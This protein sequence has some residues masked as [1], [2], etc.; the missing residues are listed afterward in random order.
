MTTSEL[1]QEALQA[2]NPRRTEIGRPLP[3]SAST[4][5]LLLAAGLVLPTA[6]QSAETGEEEAEEFVLEEV[7][8]TGS[9]IRRTELSDAPAPMAIVDSEEIADRQFVNLID[10]ISEIQVG[11][12][13][14]NKGANDL[15]GDNF[16]FVDLLSL[17]SQRTLTL[18][19]GRRVVPSNMGTVFVPGN[20][21]GAQV[22]LSIINPMAVERVEVVSG[23]GGAVYG[24]DAVAGVVNIIT[25]QDF[26]GFNVDASGSLT[27]NSGK[28][29][30]RLSAIWGTN[31]MDRRLNFMVAGEYSTSQ[32]IRTSSDRPQAYMGSAITNPANG[33]TRNPDYSAAAAAAALAAGGTPPP[34]FLPSTTDAVPS[35]LY[36][37]LDLRSPLY[38][39]NGILMTGQLLQGAASSTAFIPPTTS[40]VPAG[41]GAAVDPQGFAFFAPGALTAAQQADPAAIITALGG[42]VDATALSLAQQRT[43]A[44]Q[45]LQA[46]RPTPREYA[47]QNSLD[48]LLFTAAFG[49]N[50]TYPR[51]ANTD[52]A[53]SALFPLVSAPLQFDPAGNL[54]P[55]N[56]GN[57]APPNPG[58]V[59]SVFGG[60]GFDSYA[61]GY[62]QVRSGTRR[63][64]FSAQHTFHVSDRIRWTGEYLYTDM[65]FKS[66]QYSGSWINSPTGTA[67]AGNRSIPVYLDQN[68]FLTDQA[69]GTIDALAAQGLVIPTLDG[70]RVMYLGRAMT[71]FLESGP[72]ERN[73]VETW[74]IAQGLNGDFSAWGRPFYWDVSAAYGEAKAR[75]IAPDILDIEFALATDVVDGPDGPVCRQ[76]MLAA[77]EPINLRN[78]Q[79]A[80][81]NTRLPLTPTAEQVA[82]CRPLNLFGQGAASQEAIDYVT[83]DGGTTNKNKQEYYAASLGS[84]LFELPGGPLGVV[85]QA[86]RRVESI[87]FSP[88]AAA[89]VGA[90]RNT[91]IL[92]NTG[93]LKFTE[94]GAEVRVPLFGR[95]FAFP[96]IQAL[97]LEG[98]IRRVDREQTT[99]S[100][101]YPDPGPSVEDDVY[102]VGV[103]WI[104]IDDLVLRGNISTSVRSAS[105]VELFS[106][107]SSGFGAAD[108]PC[109]ISQITLGPSPDVRRA[110]CLT[111]VQ[112]LGVAGNEADA[113][114]FLNS[115]V[116]TTSS[117]PAAATGNPFLQN[118]KAEAWSVGLTWKPAFVPGLQV[119]MDYVELEL[120][121]EI[122]LYAPD[123]YLQNC[124]DSPSFPD[125][126]VGGTP[127][128]D[129]ATLGVQQGGGYVIPDINPV[130]GAPVAGGAVPGQSAT[131]Q[132]PFEWAF[133]Q[134]PNFNLGKRETRVLNID[135]RYQFPLDR[136]LGDRAAEWGTL[137]LRASAFFTRQLDLYADGETHTDKVAGSRN[138][139]RWRTR[140]EVSHR[141]GGLGNTLQWFWRQKTVD[142]PFQDPTQYGELTP[143]FVN[144]DYSFLNYSGSWELRDDV[145][146]RF[147]INNLTDARG[148]NG[149]LGDAYDLGVGREFILGVSLRL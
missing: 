43:L 92:A 57:I 52:P 74:R 42:G 50:G 141:I 26:E 84:D 88:G 103:R 145:T 118:E 101:F 100:E 76:Q 85:V 130:T 98:A 138:V 112:M 146:L 34:V 114:A 132:G 102:S 15:Y 70:Q 46:N 66:P 73:E 65:T 139:P 108:H 4:L 77:P 125:T 14:T 113:A 62:Q 136:M 78:P 10:A 117:R 27:E 96:G 41:F 49:G 147:T 54:V 99:R 93:E 63:A 17:G 72:I 106:A 2:R 64:T 67:T 48:P 135:T 140:A 111:A 116:N 60:E 39:E 121:Q 137:A 37:P 69:L 123:D 148:P 143:A 53:T 1:Y 129:L 80:S 3:T 11:E 7:I 18:I 32:L 71:D 35:S 68:P 105:L 120:E 24:A 133:Y 104:P 126:Q 47:L 22:D 40:G 28:G 142:D 83:A 119:G 55:Y 45:L 127:V 144:S 81:I 87:G 124:F 61:L 79:L 90:A 56:I 109:S 31:L 23:T 44:L 107:P 89:S 149:P 5:S 115:L 122:A 110:N 86:E 6:A 94:Y 131:V 51:I 59:G 13:L 29:G 75:N 134:Y 95:D 19:N 97:E 12:V 33:A 38:N 16:A 9:R 30:G 36:G 128:C 82:A 20:A 25:R 8:V 91:T 21:S 58:Y